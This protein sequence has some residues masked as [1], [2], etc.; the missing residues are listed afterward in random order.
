[1]V[2]PL[3]DDNP[4]KL[5]HRPL[6]TWGLIVANIVIFFAEVGAAAGPSVVVRI[7]GLTPAALVGDLSIPDALSPALTLFS[8][9]F[10]HADIMHLLG[11]MIFLWVFGDDIEECLGRLRFLGF[12]VATGGIAGLV[13]VVSDAHSQ[14]PLI[15]A[16]GA[17]AGVAIAYVMLRPCAKVT[18]LTFGIIPMRISAYWVVGV[19]VALQFINLESA[20]KSEVAYWCHIGGMAAGGVLFPLLR[21]VGVRLFECIRAPK[22]PVIVAG[23][24]HLRGPGGG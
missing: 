4:F 22:V 5:P 19:F 7:Y 12:Y 17:I 6:V 23:T 11:N 14:A 20:S 1:M 18:V 8:Y 13:Y 24:E 16:S 21:P 10:L 9:Q 2:M 3:Y 15:G